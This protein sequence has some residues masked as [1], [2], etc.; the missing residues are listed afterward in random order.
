VFPNENHSDQ[1]VASI[2]ARDFDLTAASF[3]FWFA[4]FLGSMKPADFRCE[5]LQPVSRSELN[6]MVL[7]SVGYG[8]YGSFISWTAKSGL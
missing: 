2:S 6:S 4:G 1:A 8:F 7:R 5:F 3:I